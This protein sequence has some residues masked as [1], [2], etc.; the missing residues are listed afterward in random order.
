MARITKRTISPYKGKVIDLTVEGSHTYNIESLGVH[1]S[2]A[3]SLAAYA[4]GI[5]QVDPIKYDLLFSRFLQTGERVGFVDNNRGR[6]VESDF[7]ELSASDGRTI[8]LD[9]RLSVF[10][11][12]NGNKLEVL[13]KDIIEGDVLLD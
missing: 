11:N 4:L 13:V 2:A 6:P 10:V 1:N 8:T 7:V 12:R 5:T 9:T 3:G